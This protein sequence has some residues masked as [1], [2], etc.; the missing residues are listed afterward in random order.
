LNIWIVNIFDSLPGE[1]LRPGRYAHLAQML[2]AKG[3]K[4][5]WWSSNFYHATKSFRS[6]EQEAIQ[7]N[8]N[9][10]IILLETPRYNKN[11]SLRRIWS[12]YRYAIAL[13]A[14]GI[15]C[16][17]APDIF[18]AS[19]VP[20]SVA[21]TASVL[22]KRFSAKFIIDVQD[23]WPESFELIFPSRLRWL[24]KILLSPLRLFADRIYTKADAL[25]AISLTLL[26]RALS[27]SKNKPKKT[28]VLPLAV[29]IAL[30]RKY[31][32]LVEEDVPFIK[33]SHD[34]FWATYAGTIGKAYDVRAILEA[35][36]RLAN[37]QPNI[38]FFI[39]GIGPDYD[40]MRS[41]ASKK[42]LAYV[43]FTGLLSYR[44]VVHLLNQSDVGLST[45]A[46]GLQNAFPNKVFDYLAAGL[47]IANSAE[48][49][50]GNLVIAERIGLQY[51][52]GNAE[53]LAKAIVAL[54]NNPHERLVMGQMARRLAEERFDMNKEYPRFE[55]FLIELDRREPNQEP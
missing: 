8:K 16:T 55:G 2:A 45:Y 25:T 32:S 1:S 27:P 22:A 42:K 12:H 54:Y 10:R 30:F 21:N 34:A 31:E 17:E 40:K 35:A 24:A 33:H 23:L 49:E 43:T 6:Q 19:S 9:L 14:E 3:H 7:V 37:S 51:E 4:V 38:R 44:N 47:P 29:D 13:K 18:L 41:Y 20:L 11:I 52:A 26:Q 53:S 5:T 28:M 15:K 39:A 46:V 50:L 36:D 48:G